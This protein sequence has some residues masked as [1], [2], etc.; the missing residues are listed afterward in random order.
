MVM[1]RG[2]WAPDVDSARMIF[3]PRGR[4]VRGHGYD[5]REGVAMAFKQVPWVEAATS[6][7]TARWPR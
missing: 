1:K 6:R 5:L 2:T 3:R 4:Q 7:S